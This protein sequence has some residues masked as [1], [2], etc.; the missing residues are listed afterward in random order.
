MMTAYSTGAYSKYRHTDRN[1]AMLGGLTLFGDMRRS[2]TSCWS[3]M[4]FS[5]S[6]CARRKRRPDSKQHLD[7]TRRSAASL[8]YAHKRVIA[9]GVFRMHGS[10][11]TEDS[12]V[13]MQTK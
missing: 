12:T 2:I 11:S 1:R 7:Q 9:D 5:G 10:R 6:S 3:R 4:R 13:S 8:P